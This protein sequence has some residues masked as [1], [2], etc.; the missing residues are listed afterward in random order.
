MDLFSGALQMPSSTYVSRLL[1]YL[2]SFSLLYLLCQTDENYHRALVW[3]AV[4]TAIT[5]LDPDFGSVFAIQAVNEPIMDA[6][7]TPGFGDCKQIVLVR[8]FKTLISEHRCFLSPNKFCEGSS[9]RRGRAW[10]CV[11]RRRIPSKHDHQQCH[12]VSFRS[13]SRVVRLCGIPSAIWRCTDAGGHVVRTRWIELVVRWSVD[14]F[15]VD[16]KVSE[17]LKFAYPPKWPNKFTPNALA[18]WTSIGNIIMLPTRQQLLSA[19]RPMIITFIIRKKLVPF[20]FRIVLTFVTSFGGVADP[21]PDAYLSSICSMLSHLILLVRTGS[22]KFSRSRSRWSRRRGREQPDVVRRVVTFHEFWWHRWF[23]GAIRRCAEDC[24]FQGRGMDR[25]SIRLCRS[26]HFQTI[27]QFWNF[28]TES[29]DLGRGWSYFEGVERGFF[30]TD[31]SVIQ[32][33]S[34]C[35]AYI[36]Q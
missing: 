24:V 10:D 34:V 35:D 2:N 5:H 4:M 21:T 18:T 28:K 7:Q 31:P 15:G 11:V 13:V 32:N 22:D 6:S 12:S 19:P 9:G 30:S 8:I 29:S 33:P 36:T 1:F 25:E 20:T 17:V 23:P 3:T 16:Y 26:W 14:D 27:S